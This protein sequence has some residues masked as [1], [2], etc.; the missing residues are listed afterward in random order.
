LHRKFTGYGLRIRAAQKS[1]K[2]GEVSLSALRQQSQKSETG[3]QARKCGLSGSAQ[4]HLPGTGING[5]LMCKKIHV[6]Q[7]LF[8]VYHNVFTGL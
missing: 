3:K 4:R 7:S 2:I 8:I 6:N 5:G 1:D